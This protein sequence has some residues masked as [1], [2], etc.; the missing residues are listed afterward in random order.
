MFKNGVVTKFC[1]SVW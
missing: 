1:Y